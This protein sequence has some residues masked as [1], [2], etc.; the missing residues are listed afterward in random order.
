MDKSDSLE[1]ID[2]KMM[3]MGF[4][5]KL[6]ENGIDVSDNNV[7]MNPTFIQFGDT[8]EC[9][10]QGVKLHISATNKADYMNLLNN[11]LP[12]LVACGATFKVLR[13]DAFDHLYESETQAG[14]RS[15]YIRRH[16][17]EH[18]IS[19]GNIRSCSKKKDTM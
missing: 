12:D 10:S 19:F 7:I 4:Y 13:L 9:P 15:R 1:Y 14:S 11:I 2:D 5:M 8:S 17:L 6:R 3:N 18:T 16:L